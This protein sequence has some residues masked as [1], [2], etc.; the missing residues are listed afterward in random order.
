M[1]DKQLKTFGEL[2][3]GD[4]FMIDNELCIKTDDF[5]L[6]TRPDV[7]I[8]ALKLTD[9]TFFHL[10]DDDNVDKMRV[11]FSAYNVE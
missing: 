6:D 11:T 5:I 10:R 4:K 3:V 7:K 1:T 8:N 9:G 2:W